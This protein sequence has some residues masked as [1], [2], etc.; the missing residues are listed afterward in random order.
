MVEQSHS[1]PES[2]CKEYINHP[3]GLTLSTPALVISFSFYHDLDLTALCFLQSYESE[4]D[5][6]AKG[7][8]ITSGE[9]ENSD[10]PFE[11]ILQ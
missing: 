5:E 9:N 2:I 8:H 11:K 7:M 3:L 1:T 10:T 6:T 4:H